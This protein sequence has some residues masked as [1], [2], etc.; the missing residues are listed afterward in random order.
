MRFRAYACFLSLLTIQLLGPAAASAGDQDQILWYRDYDL[1]L[2]EAR[3]LN[4]PVFA[5]VTSKWS[6][7]GLRLE[8]STFVDPQLVGLVSESFIAVYVDAD[9][10]PDLANRLTERVPTAVVVSVAGA[11]L[12]RVEGYRSV[13][14]YVGELNACL[15]RPKAVSAPSLAR[16]AQPKVKLAQVRVAE[17]HASTD[18]PHKAEI[19]L[20]DH[21]ERRLPHADGLFGAAPNPAPPDPPVTADNAPATADEPTATANSTVAADATSTTED[22]TVPAETTSTP[23]NPTV[24]AAVPSAPDIATA[25]ATSPFGAARSTAANLPAPRESAQSPANTS[26]AMLAGCCPVAMIETK[27]LVRGD[28]QYRMSFSGETIWFS[29][30]EQLQQFR[31]DPAR[32]LPVLGGNCAVTFVDEGREVRG[33]P[34]FGALFRNRLYLFAGPDERSRFQ[35]NPKH[36]VDCD[37]A[38]DGHCPVCGKDQGQLV[39]GSRDIQALYARRI[40]RFDSDEHRRRFRARPD[41]FGPEN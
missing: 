2:N 34:R 25:P 4:R 29:G 35:T 38:G 17:S 21:A 10:S 26:N 41:S 30:P 23:E 18:A 22:T 27:K 11:E 5:F 32:Y 3:L 19:K 9:A 28:A 1:A 6:P 39:P 8:R 20:A 40:Y 24:S 14:S 16:V 13:E 37:L 36:Y 15:G 7:S 12:W 31:A 33:E